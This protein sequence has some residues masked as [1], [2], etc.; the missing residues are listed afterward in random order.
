MTIETKIEE[1]T[2]IAI[3]L[4]SLWKVVFHNDDAT[5]MEFVIELL[6]IIFKR[7]EEDARSITLEIHN[8]GAG[9]AGVY[10]HEIAEQK[11]IEATNIARQ[12][13]H[14]LVITVE[15]DA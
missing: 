7:S 15:K 3:K 6:K 12:N 4:P 5:P 14:P 11:G 10:H 2:T 13:G 8:T 9:V 1:N